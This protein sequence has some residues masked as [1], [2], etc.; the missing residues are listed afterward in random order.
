VLITL[1]EDSAFALLDIGRSPGRVEMMQG[2]EARLD[3][4]AFSHLCCAAEKNADYSLAHGFEEHR[5]GCIV[6]G[7]L[8]ERDLIRRNA[9][10]DKLFAHVIIDRKPAAVRLRRREIAKDKLRAFRRR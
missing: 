4:S 2:D 6:G 7:V 5:F 8:R 10:R 1:P 9:A 3:I